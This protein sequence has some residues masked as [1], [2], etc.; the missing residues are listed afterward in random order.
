MF[1]Q[2]ST[3]AMLVPP[4]AEFAQRRS[5]HAQWRHRCQRPSGDF[6]QQAS[7]IARDEAAPEEQAVPPVEADT[8]AVALR[9]VSGSAIIGDKIVGRIFGERRAEHA[10]VEFDVIL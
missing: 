8:Y 7:L 10:R 6:G 2:V 5:M 9:W 3:G 4:D 1:Q